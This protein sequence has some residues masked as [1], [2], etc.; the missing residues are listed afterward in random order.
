LPLGT[1]GCQSNYLFMAKRPNK[2]SPVVPEP[3][4][5]F[6]FWS[7]VA[8]SVIVVVVMVIDYVNGWAR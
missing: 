3:S 4:T 5:R 1:S 7:G 2:R 6:L 8:A